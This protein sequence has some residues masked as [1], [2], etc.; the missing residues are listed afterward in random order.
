MGVRDRAKERLDNEP[1]AQ[2]EVEMRL[3]HVCAK[4]ALDESAS[5]RF[6]AVRRE[7]HVM[8]LDADA[9]KVLKD[10]SCP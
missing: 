4:S 1:G 10:A 2:I 8:P 3:G 6:E 9:M 5:P 7:P